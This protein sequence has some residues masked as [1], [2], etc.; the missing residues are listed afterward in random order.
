[1]LVASPSAAS[2]GSRAGRLS[3]FIWRT[4]AHHKSGNGGAQHDILHLHGYHGGGHGCGRGCGR[5][6]CVGE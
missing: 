1:M 6:S 3:Y 4:I 5:G 2:F